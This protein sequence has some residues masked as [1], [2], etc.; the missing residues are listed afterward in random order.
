MFTKPL[1]VNLNWRDHVIIRENFKPEYQ[2]LVSQPVLIKSLGWEPQ[3]SI[4]D[5]AK[6]MMEK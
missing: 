2:I 6:M 5:L 3:T 4:E 1:A